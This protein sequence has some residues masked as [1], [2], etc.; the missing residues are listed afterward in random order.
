MRDGD[1]Y[2]KGEKFMRENER[3]KAQKEKGDPISLDLQGCRERAKLFCPWSAKN[4][5]VLLSLSLLF[6]FDLFPLFDLSFL[7]LT[8]FFSTPVV[9]LAVQKNSQ[10][11]G[12][13]S[14]EDNV[15]SA[16]TCILSLRVKSI[17]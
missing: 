8:L 12:P 7:S 13:P 1:L 2:R 11:Q 9:V 5:F 4:S 17:C 14:F 15:C 16:Q 6:P 10:N 3:E